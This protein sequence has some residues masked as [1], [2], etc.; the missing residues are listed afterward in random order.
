MN[1]HAGYVILNFKSVNFMKLHLE[2]EWVY[3]WQLL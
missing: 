3:L 1:G 2:L